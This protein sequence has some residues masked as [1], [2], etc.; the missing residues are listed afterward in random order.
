MSEVD[1]PTAFTRGC[2]VRASLPVVRSTN[3]TKDRSLGVLYLQYGDETKQIRMPNEITSIDTIRALFVSA[4]PQQLNMK[5]LESPSVAVY[6][7]DD[8]RNMYYELTDVRN[9]TD[10]SCLKVYHK[11]PA[12]AFS[13][14]PRPANGDARMH[15]DMA[16]A[17]R[18][19]QHPL[20]HPP[21]GPP[22]HPSLQG[23]LPPTPHS[24]PPSPSRIPF[25]P[26]QNSAPG[27]ATIPRDR[28]S[29]VN[30][31]ARSISPCP[32]AILERRDVKP[33][34]DLG[35]KSHTLTRG[36][37]GLYADPYLLQEGRISMAAGHGPH[38][39]PGLD[40]PEH[41]MGGFHRASI[42]S[43]SSYG[44]PSPT[45]SVDHSPL[46]R[47]KSRNSQLPTLGSKTPPPSP[48]RMTEV[49]M[50]DIHSLPPHAVPP[51]TTPD[52]KSVV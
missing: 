44:G 20:R 26:R 37:E 39:S 31:S 28:M 41:G 7:K 36:N 52:R 17:A 9:I 8:M 15:S 40:G 50:I 1:A 27:S 6:V 32:S 2:R 49:R 12:Q 10:H 11:D 22:S 14:G 48:H 47:Q 43:T 25:G 38:G 24:M 21:L 42:R 51:H 34:Q 3:Q 19:G 35:G 13:H 46:Y 5:M 23:A 29:N 16:H 4:F 33:D 30:P 18:D 45:D